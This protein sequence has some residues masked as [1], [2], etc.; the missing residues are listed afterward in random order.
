[1]KFL[2]YCPVYS[3]ALLLLLLNVT[4][5]TTSVRKVSPATID[6]VSLNSIAGSDEKTSQIANK[7]PEEL[8]RSGFV[9]LV[10]KDFTL[11]NMHFVSALQKQPNLP[12]AYFGLARTNQQQGNFEGAQENYQKALKLQPD[13]LQA[14]IG[15][16]QTMRLN[17]RLNDAIKAINQAMLVSPDDVRVL[18]ELAIIYVTMGK[19]TL[20]EPLYQEIVERAPDQASSYNNLGMN[21]LLKKQYAQ[22]I[23]EFQQALAINRQDKRVKN[24]LATALALYGDTNSA[25]EIFKATVGEAAAYNNIGYL[26]LTQGRLDEAEKSLIAALKINPKFYTRAQENLDRLNYLRK[27]QIAN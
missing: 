5:C 21:Y 7:T 13:L 3:L 19:E 26:L 17:D 22:A 2:S 8:V 23:I 12:L 25:L 1:M 10:R 14:H 9:Y 24:N 27:T 11:A 6:Q 4:G 18:S 16:A 20:A 15:L